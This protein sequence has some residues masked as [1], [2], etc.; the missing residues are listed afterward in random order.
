MSSLLRKMVTSLHTWHIFQPCIPSVNICE[1]IAKL[2]LTDGMALG[3]SSGMRA[4]KWTGTAMPFAEQMRPVA[5]C[6]WSDV[7]F[8][9]EANVVFLNTARFVPKWYGD[10]LG[11]HSAGDNIHITFDVERI[12]TPT[13]LE[14]RSMRPCRRIVQASI[15]DPTEAPA[16]QNLPLKDSECQTFKKMNFSKESFH[17]EVQLLE[18]SGTRPGI[19]CDSNLGYYCIEMQ[20][21]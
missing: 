1:H 15:G 10:G 14:T 7:A 11:M 6:W 8:C 3:Q 2:L 4:L 19:P 13:I 16:Q 12:L 9:L 18:R 5:G 20:R 17:G 21:W